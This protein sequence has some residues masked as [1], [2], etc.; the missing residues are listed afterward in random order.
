MLNKCRISGFADEISPDFSVQLNVLQEIGQKF[1]ELRAA[2]EIN[3]SDMTKA[4]ATEFYDR[5]KE[6]GVGVSALGSPIGKIQITEDFVPHF[7]KYCH[8]VELTKIFNTPYIRMF[9]FYMPKEEDP[10]KYQ[11]EVF[12]RTEQMVEYAKKQNVILLHE[13]EKGIYGDMAPRCRKLMEAFFGEH[14]QCTFDFANFVQCKQDTREAYEMLKPYIRYVHVKDALWESGEV[15]PAGDG[16]GNVSKILALLDAS[17][18]DGYLS[19]EPHLTNFAG[20]EK[21]EPDVQKRKENNGTLAYKLAYSKLQEIL[22]R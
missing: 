18:Y 8:T 14:Y 1:I 12:K 3:V 6:A 5:M 2:D 16:Q 9:S 15:V 20:L 4:Q 21:L 11:D 13:N 22:G 7:E 19:L 17:G 10:E